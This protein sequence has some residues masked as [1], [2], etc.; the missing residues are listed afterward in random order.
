MKEVEVGI[1]AV[2]LVEIIPVGMC[3][4]VTTTRICRI[5]VAG[6]TNKV[7]VFACTTVFFEAF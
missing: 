3:C 6:V 1:A 5:L 7:N 2:L 4:V